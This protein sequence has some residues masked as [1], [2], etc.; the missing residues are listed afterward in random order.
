MIP[1]YS[2]EGRR[3]AATQPGHA[4]RRK[5][6]WCESSHSVQPQDLLSSMLTYLFLSGHYPCVAFGSGALQNFPVPRLCC[7]TTSNY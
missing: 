3:T 6:R 1:E 7:A 2:L 4:T 5:C